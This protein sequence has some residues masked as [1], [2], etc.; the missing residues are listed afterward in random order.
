MGHRTP[1][2]KSTS[3]YLL[4]RIEYAERLDYFL[5][6]RLC[7]TPLC[8]P[9]KVAAPSSQACVVHYGLLPFLGSKKPTVTNGSYFSLVCSS[10]FF[11]D[12]NQVDLCFALILCF[13]Y[14]LL[15]YKIM[16]F[17][18]AFSYVYIGIYSH[19][20]IQGCG[21]GWIFSQDST[22]CVY[23]TFLYPSI[24]L[25]G[26]RQGLTM[27][28]GQPQFTMYPRLASNYLSSDLHP[29]NTMIIGLCQDVQ[30]RF[31]YFFI[32]FFPEQ[33]PSEGLTCYHQPTARKPEKHPQKREDAHPLP[34]IHTMN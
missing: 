26:L 6:F 21:G 13:K 7:H 2:R 3:Q 18:V 1:G 25:F 19:N 22:V 27:Q 12:Q 33:A 20:S 8:V 10:K 11:R 15:L 32:Y 31:L 5:E 4:F 30:P 16:D 28:L 17:A 34:P 29:L 14:F 9:K 23:A 24:C